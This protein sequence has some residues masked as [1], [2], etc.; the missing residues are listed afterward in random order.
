MTCLTVECLRHLVVVGKASMLCA[1][2]SKLCSTDTEA[3]D[4][5]ALSSVPSRSRRG[6]CAGWAAGHD[7]LFE[8]PAGQHP[9]SCLSC[10][11]RK[12]CGT[13]PE[14]FHTAKVTCM[15]LNNL[16]SVWL[17]VKSLSILSGTECWP[18]SCAPV[19]CRAHSSTVEL[20]QAK[21][22]LLS[23]S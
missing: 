23:P 8:L 15:Y 12:S 13:A 6:Q 21:S 16:R 19:V 2:C 18:V 5:S 14:L 11:C 9:A 22:A 1:W 10:T 20:F 17:I 3:W 4:A 7:S